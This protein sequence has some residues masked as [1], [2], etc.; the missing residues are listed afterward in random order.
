MLVWTLLVNTLSYWANQLSILGI[1]L[2]P[3]IRKAFQTGCPILQLHRHEIAFPG[4]KA[5]WKS[6]KL[7]N[8]VM[9]CR[10][11][12]SSLIAE[13]SGPL[14]DPDRLSL[15]YKVGLYRWFTT[16]QYSV[17]CTTL[18]SCRPVFAVEWKQDENYCQGHLPLSVWRPPLPTQ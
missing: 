7:Y 4:V 14:L 15:L 18:N 12:P 11:K 16:R 6:L 3:G 10:S 13:P 2:N 1:R 17:Y 8:T 5:F 9:P